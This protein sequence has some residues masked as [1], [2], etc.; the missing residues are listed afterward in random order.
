MR[1]IIL[2]LVLLVSHSAF[3]PHSVCCEEISKEKSAF[4]VGAAYVG[5]AV[6]N[7]SG[8]IKTGT[9]YLGMATI[10]VGFNTSQAGWWKGGQFHLHA[11]NTHGASPSV[12]LLGDFQVASNIEAGNHTYVQE[13]WFKQSAGKMEF[14]VGLQDLNV[15]FVNTHYGAHYFN[16][17]F[18]VMPVISGNFAAPIF[19]LT[20]LGITGKWNIS[21]KTSWLNALYDGNPAG[22]NHN[23]HNLR[24]SYNEGDGIL[25]ITEIQHNTNCNE[26]TATYKIGVFYRN[27]IAEKILNISLPD[28]LNKN[29]T[30]IYAVIDKKV[31]KEVNK[32][33]GVFTQLGCSPTADSQCNIYAGLGINFTG[34]FSKK[35]N[36]VLGLALAHVG[37]RGKIKDETAYEL[38]Y[39]YQINDHLFIQ[40]DIQYIIHPAGTDKTL[41]NSFA[42]LLRVGVEI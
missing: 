9:D 8:G 2:F 4:T 39:R 5:N 13:L 29:Q 12:E 22:F 16:S 36:D 33:L 23:P 35:G 27:H 15:E 1:R 14:T 28:S 26:L 25:A 24:W 20:T 10:R 31:W 37:F 38:S 19:P 17:S 11:V 6:S 41:N 7:F 42:G 18:G 3:I 32:N 30:G 40:P 21:E 34:L